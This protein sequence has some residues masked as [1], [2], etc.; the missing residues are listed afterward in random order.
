[1]HF[2]PLPQLVSESAGVTVSVKVNI[3]FNIEIF[4]YLPVHEGAGS[5]I[6]L[7]G[8]SGTALPLL[9]TIPA[10]AEMVAGELEKSHTMENSAKKKKNKNK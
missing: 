1:M 7:A 5:A 3:L 9:K 10:K 6:Q 8:S 4:S 2:S